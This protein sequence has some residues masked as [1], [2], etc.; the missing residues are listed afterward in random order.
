FIDTILIILVYEM[1][2]PLIRPLFLRIW[3]SLALVLAIDTLLFVTGGF[4][5]HP[6]Y[7]EILLSG[8]VGKTGAALVY[9]AALT[10]YLPRA[11]VA[12]PQT[13]DRTRPGL[14]DLFQVLTYR[15]KYE[16]LRVQITRD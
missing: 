12:D 8:V 14:G 5:E 2:S 7:R 10:L 16:A 4:A 1:V 13:T 9:A 15:Q 3:V 6:A 11:L